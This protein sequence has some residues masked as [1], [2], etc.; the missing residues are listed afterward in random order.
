MI[1]SVLESAA[2]TRIAGARDAQ[3]AIDSPLIG[4][5][6]G[7]VALVI[8][9]YNAFLFVRRALQQLLLRQH[10]IIVSAIGNRSDYRASGGLIRFVNKAPQVFF[11]RNQFF[12][13]SSQIIAFIEGK[14]ARIIPDRADV[15]TAAAD[16]GEGRKSQ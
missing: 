2:A 5:S 11:A 14:L 6:D 15:I 4:L 10:R 9:R 16:D 7:V 1:S 8:R 12:P 3:K 13:P